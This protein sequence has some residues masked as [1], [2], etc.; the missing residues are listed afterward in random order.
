M[1]P[2]WSARSAAECRVSGVPDEGDRARDGGWLRPRGVSRSRESFD[3][4]RNQFQ[5]AGGHYFAG[6]LG[7]A[8]YRTPLRPRILERMPHHVDVDLISDAPCYSNSTPADLVRP[9]D[10]LIAE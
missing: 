10:P 7:Y 1:P 6:G 8:N 5:G 2:P 4:S 9:R 3:R